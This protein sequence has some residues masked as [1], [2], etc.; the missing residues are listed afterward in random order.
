ITGKLIHE[1]EQACVTC[2][3]V[4]GIIVSSRQGALGNWTANLS[5]ADTAVASL[6]VKRGD[7]IEFIA[8]GKK[9]SSGDDFKWQVTVRRLEPVA[10]EKNEWDSVRDFY[11]PLAQPMNAWEK[12]AQALLAAVEFLLID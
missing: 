10:N 12:Y 7:T 2:D 5:Q 6:E 3:G 11:S 9:N 4:E 1:F 8:H